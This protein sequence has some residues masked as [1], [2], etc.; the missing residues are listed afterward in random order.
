M[1]VD[2]FALLPQ[3]LLPLV[4]EPLCF[5]ALQQ[6]PNLQLELP[7][8]TLEW[9]TRCDAL[10]ENAE[11]VAN[12]MT[13]GKRYRAGVCAALAVQWRAIVLVCSHCNGIVDVTMVRKS[14]T[15]TLRLVHMAA[16]EEAM[17]ATTAAQSAT[18]S[19][20]TAQVP[21][22]AGYHWDVG[23]VFEPDVLEH[24]AEEVLR[25]AK[26]VEVAAIAARRAAEASRTEARVFI[27]RHNAVVA[28]RTA[29][30]AAKT[31]E[32][33]LALADNVVG[34]M[35][36]RMVCRA[37]KRELYT[38]KGY[39][40][41][42]YYVVVSPDAQAWNAVADI[43]GTPRETLFKAR[44]P[45]QTIQKLISAWCLKWGFERRH[46]RFVVGDITI[47][48][49]ESLLALRGLFRRTVLTVLPEAGTLT[50]E[51]A[52]AVVDAEEEDEEDL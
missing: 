18:R 41:E 13:I 51:A 38:L 19:V 47:T 9:S 42:V 44:G 29:A 23:A 27:E 49:D 10:L 8:N 48:G 12:L 1:T 43:V 36:P 20:Y 11:K 4:L 35:I 21:R 5:V 40:Y 15:A 37:V 14:C 3:E 30:K 50:A 34:Q 39:G 24:N 33:V 26:A 45:L 7:M 31:A 16:E 46:V 25:Q 6:P 22:V 52:E 2:Y 17:S 32:D 28:A